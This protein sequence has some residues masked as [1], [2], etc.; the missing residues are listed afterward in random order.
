MR[1][2]VSPQYIFAMLLLCSV[3]GVRQDLLFAQE[4][5]PVGSQD[6][7]TAK[8]ATE[9]VPPMEMRDSAA[10]ETLHIP[11]GHSLIL[12]GVGALKRVYIGNPLV[13]Q[14]FTAGPSEIVLTAKIPGVSDLV[15]WDTVGQSRIYTVEADL[16]SVDLRRSLQEAYPGSKFNVEGRE[17]RMYLS[18]TVATPEIA[19]GIFKLASSHSKDIVNGLRVALHGKQVQLKLRI[20]EVDRTKMEQYGVN[21]AGGGNNP[22]A[23]STQ[24]FA[25]PTPVDGVVKY[26]DPLNLLLFSSKLNVAATVKDLEQKQILEV[27]AEPTLTTMSGIPAKFLS[28]GE[29]PYPIV[30]SSATGG[31]TAA[32]TI[33]F[34]PYG[35]RVDFTPT[36]N[37]DGS[38]RLKVAP[39]VSTLDFTNAVT[40]SG[41]TV[42][43]LSTRRAET[44]VEI[45]SGQSFALSGI[46]DHRT[47]ENLSQMPGISRIPILGK[48]LI[49]KSY[50]HSVV[51]LVVVVTATVVDPLTDS[52]TP[53]EPAMVAP[54]LDSGTFDHDLSR[55]QKLP[56]K[57]P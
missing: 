13:L 31:V 43:A 11:V 26:T 23:L 41:F 17:G 57:K 24:Q 45:R 5:P 44:E 20:V 21:F 6:Q 7:A 52:T 40:I 2:F 47:T 36:V 1:K 15:L 54:H 22:F 29:F 10:T 51:E 14:S 25:A 42:P 3:C 34:R 49:T 38:I 46:L 4:L 48:L 8:V 28:G 16:D 53:A 27:L 39:E 55:E 32:I 35:I 9:V 12:K 19:D 18:G 56:P 37:D 33:S 30:Q 50:T